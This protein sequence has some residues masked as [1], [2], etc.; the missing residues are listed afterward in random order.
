MLLLILQDRK[1]IIDPHILELYYHEIKGINC[2]SN[3][4]NTLCI[5]LK[6]CPLYQIV[7]Y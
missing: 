6:I 4:L 3:M 5:M 2:N 7:L 1:L